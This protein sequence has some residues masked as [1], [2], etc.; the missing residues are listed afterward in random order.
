MIIS[1]YNWF[2]YWVAIEGFELA[3]YRVKQDAFVRE[4]FSKVQA[5]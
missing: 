1:E 2:R 5:S 4:L 3:Y